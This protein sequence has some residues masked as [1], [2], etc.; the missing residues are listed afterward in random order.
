MLSVIA[1][2]STRSRIAVAMTRSPKTSPQAAKLWLLVRLK[3]EQNVVAPG[4]FQGGRDEIPL[5]NSARTHHSGNIEFD[6]GQSAV[7]LQ[8]CRFWFSPTI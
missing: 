5:A 8:G 1:W 6:L 7:S 4:I 2:C 3:L